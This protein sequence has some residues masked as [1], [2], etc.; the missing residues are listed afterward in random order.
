MLEFLE[1]PRPRPGF[2]HGRVVKHP[3]RVVTVAASFHVSQQ[4]TQTGRLTAAMFDQVLGRVASLLDA[5]A[6]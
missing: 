1:W 3:D 2:S 5:P 6:G 4:N